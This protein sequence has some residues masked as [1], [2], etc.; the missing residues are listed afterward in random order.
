MSLPN[1]LTKII[2]LSKKKKQK[3]W[4]EKN[5]LSADVSFYYVPVTMN[6]LMKRINHLRL[7]VGIVSF[8]VV[9]FVEIDNW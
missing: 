9:K 5:V 2:K 3:K 7:T 4:K 8:K 6:L 1:A